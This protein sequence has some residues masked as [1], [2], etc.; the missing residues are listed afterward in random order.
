LG[1]KGETSNTEEKFKE[2][3]KSKSFHVGQGS[4]QV[5]YGKRSGY[6]AIKKNKKQLMGGGKQLEKDRMATG[7]KKKRKQ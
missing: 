7:R 5:G 6:S 2:Q 3:T 4:V 1:K